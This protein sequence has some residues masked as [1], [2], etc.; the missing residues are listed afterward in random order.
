MNKEIFTDPRLYPLLEE[1]S[2]LLLQLWILKQEIIPTRAKNYKI[3]YGWCIRTTKEEVSNEIF[4][5]KEFK[6]VSKSEK[7]IY[8]IVKVSIYNYTPVITKLING[9]LKNQTLKTIATKLELNTSN[10]FFDV[11]YC[12]IEEQDSI[13]IR[14][15]IFNEPNSFISRNKYEKNILTSPYK[16]VPSFTLSIINLNREKIVEDGN[17]LVAIL[18]YLKEETILPFTSSG[19]TRFGNIELINTQ[20]SNEFESHYVE[21]KNIKEEV[22]IDYQKEISCKKI[23]IT[24]KPNTNTCN[25]NLLINCYLK[26]GQQVILDECKKVFHTEE[27]I[28]IEFESQEQISDILIS[29]WREEAIGFQIWYRNSVNLLR[30]IVSNIGV[31]G[32]SG[33]VKSD[34][35]STIE[36]SNSKTKEKIREAENIS[37]ASYNKMSIGNYK[38]DPWVASDKSFSKLVSSL[39]PEKSDAEFF[40]KGWD[41]EENSHGAI[42]FLEWFKKITGN[43]QKVVIQDPFYDTVGLE[44]LARTTNAKTEFVILTCT[45]INSLDDNNENTNQTEPN[46]AL[47]I[48]NLIKSNSSLFDSLKLNVYDLRS[49]GGGDKNILHDRYILIFEESE[50]RKGFHL[51]NSIQGATKKNPLLITLIPD[52]ILQKVNNHLNRIIKETENNGEIEIMSLYDYKK[53]DSPKEIQK[54]EIADKILYDKLKKEIGTKESINSKLINVLISN[55]SKTD[56]KS[57]AKFWSTFGHFLANTHFDYKILLEVKKQ[58]NKDFT[59]NL[60]EYLES[61]ITAKY[62]LGFQDE[63]RYERNDFQFLF[64]SNFNETVKTSLSLEGHIHLS[65]SYGNW[66]T[67]YGSKLLLETDFSE[68]L[69]LVQFI[70]GKFK[71]NINTDLSNTPLLKL[72]T[73]I[74]SNFYKCLFYGDNK[75]IIYKSLKSKNNIIKAISCSSLIINVIN[76]K[77]SIDFKEFQDLFSTNLSTDEALSVFTIG[78]LNHKFNRHKESDLEKDFLSVIFNLLDTNFTKERL[79]VFFNQVI[80]SNYPLIE[81]KVNGEIFIPLVETFK[82]STDIIFQLWS[83]KF[84]ELVNNIESHKNYSGIIDITGWSLNIVDDKI[85]KDFL[86]KLKKKLKNEFAEIRKPFNKG[87]L[88]WN[89]SFEKVLLIRAVLIINALYENEEKSNRDNE[90]MNIIE[91]INLIEN[92]YIPNINYSQVHQFSQQMLKEYNDVFN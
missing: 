77:E 6:K 9:L 82:I 61:S 83:F 2:K 91:E 3:I 71:K 13:I 64:R 10:L 43:A 41:Y 62:P 49:S 31:V 35:L 32:I 73:I 28:T 34:W 4:C 22:K 36:K 15:I 25:K 78:L 27:E 81:K 66:G 65:Y 53:N 85:K 23:K 57:F 63:K 69:K 50:L 47:R 48:R 51:S 24:I 1:D 38:L 37:R 18:N 86:E 11:N 5:N 75:E 12:T 92:N 40:S 58:I 17:S 29:I 21:H 26:N 70:Q 88:S 89:K 60:R 76:E 79:D 39:L 30:E 7:I 19:C 72:T 80:N 42:S 67:Y 68:F 20:C 52:N 33:T 84:L 59:K 45:Q 56:N 8:S 87:S 46:R 55:N 14:P 90:I 44:F 74:F 16:D 54:E